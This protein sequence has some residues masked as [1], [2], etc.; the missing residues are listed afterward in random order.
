MTKPGRIVIRNEV[1]ARRFLMMF[2]GFE[3]PVTIAWSPGDKRSLS[4]NALLHKWYGEVAA[5][6]GDT[7]ATTIK[8]QCHRRFG[9]TIRLRDEGFA[10]IWERTGAH[11]PYEKQ[12]RLL[13]SGILGVSSK[14]TKPEF[15]EYMEA[16]RQHYAEAGIHLTD[17]EAQRYEGAM[18]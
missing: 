4:Q 11:M 7:D 1:D 3:K 18:G 6:L 2:D 5:Q 17:P 14:M 8:G 15:T 16:M 12:C 10:W 13:G 9:L